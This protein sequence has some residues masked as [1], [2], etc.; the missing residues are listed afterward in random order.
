M[1]R[2]VSREILRRECERIR[3]EGKRIVFTNGCFDILHAGHV[4]Y[5]ARARSM[6]DVLVIGL[7]SDESVRGIKGALRPINPERERAEVLAAMASVDYVALFD[8]PDPA[9]IIRE[10]Q[11]DVLVKGGDWPVES[12]VGADQVQ[13]RGGTVVSVPFEVESSTTKIVDR[14]LARHASLGEPRRLSSQ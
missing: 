4:R 14:I 12:I 5:L 11:P 10:V 3:R 6:G 7:N 8:E 9:A 1:G 2:M 13:A